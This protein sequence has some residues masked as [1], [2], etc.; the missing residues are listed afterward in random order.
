MSRLTDTATR[1][2]SRVW[3]GVTRP[4]RTARAIR[5]SYEY[6]VGRSPREE[7]WTLNKITLYRYKPTRPAEERY[8]IPLLL[9]F[10]AINRPFLLDMR[11]GYSFIEF[12]VDEGFD[13]YLLDWGRPGPE[14]GD[15][16]LDDYGS[17]Y[18]PRAIRRVLEDSGAKEVS[19]LGYCLG[20]LIV[21]LYAALYHD[22][23]ARN[24]VL[25]TPPIDMSESDQ[26]KFHTWLDRRWFD[27]DRF[28]DDLGGLLPSWAIENGGKMLKAVANYVGAYVMLWDRID[29]PDAVA[30]WQAMHRWVHDGVPLPANVFRQWVRDYLW[31]NALVSGRHVIK[32]EVVDLG[33]VQASVLSVLAQFDHIVPNPQSLPVMELVGSEDKAVE[34]IKAGHIGIMAGSRARNVLW[35]RLASWLADRSE[36]VP[37][38]GSEEE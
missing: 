16:V 36:A 28:A 25:L 30:N 11:S 29:D 4:I 17:E 15:A 20:A 37:F 9:V 23:P 18:L 12:M 27:I 21:L 6:P 34:M 14:D 1:A 8:P 3:H 31:G 7:V 5:D 35:P 24:V 33:K 13:V 38:D 2:T 22:G 10:A 32:G 19:L 26:S